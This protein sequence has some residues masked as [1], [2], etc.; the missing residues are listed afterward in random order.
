MPLAAGEVAMSWGAGLPAPRLDS[1]TAVYESVLPGVDLRVRALVDGFT[2]A[3]VVQSAEAADNPALETLRFTLDTAGLAKRPTDS[4]GFDIVDSTGTPVLSTG[5]A[6]MWDSSSALRDEVASKSRALEEFVE[7]EQREALESVPDGARKAELPTEV[8]GSDLLVRPDLELLRGSDTTYPVVIDPWTTINRLRWGYSGT[9]DATRS[10]GVARVGRNPDGSGTYRSYFAFNLSGLSGKTVRSVKFLTEMT[11]SW[12]CDPSPVNLWRTADLTSSGKQ[13]WSG[14]SFSKWLEE[15]SG[16]AH[17][18]SGGT[19]CSNDPQPDKPM[20]FSSTTL[21]NDLI[22]NQ[23]QSNYTL[24]LSARKSDH[25]G[26]ST[27]SWWKKFDPA[28]TKLSVEYNTPPNAP[29]AGQLS[30]H[31]NYTSGAQACVT[32]TSRPM[33]RSD[34]PWL[35]ATLTDPDGANGGKLSGVFTLQKRN[36]SSWAAVSGWPKTDSGVASGAKAEVQLTTKTVDGEQ[37][38]WQVQTKDTLGG[39][40]DPSPWCE[41]YVDYSPPAVTPTVTPADGLY[42]ES[43]PL[44]TNDQVRGGVGYSGR[45]T[46]S[47]N[48]VADVYDYVYQIEGSTQLAVRAASLGGSA[49]VWVTPKHIG[50]N[51]LTVRSRDAAGNASDPYDY[52]FLADSPSAPTAVWAMN[53]GTG[54][55]LATTPAGGPIIT[56]HNNPSWTDG[57]V[58]GA[59]K[60]QGRDRAVGF[61]YGRGWGATAAAPPI[62]SSRS[63]SVAA[64]ARVLSPNTFGSVVAA[65]G[66]NNGAWQLQRDA[67]GGWFF[68]TFS[69][70]S[71]SHTRTSVTA[72]APAAINVWQHIA[73]VYD[74]GAQRIRI[75]VN[76]RLAGEQTLNSLW[77]STGV[78]QIGRVHYNGNQ[79]N[80]FEGD[81]DDVR[82]WNRVID[83]YDLE[84]LV[85]PVLSGHWEMEDLDDDSPRQEA[86]ASGY[87]RPLTLADAPAVDWAPGLGYNF[88]SGLSFDG[89]N[90]AATT[91]GPVIRTDQSYTVSAWARWTGGSGPRTVFAQDGS[92]ISGFFLTCRLQSNTVR[93]S[94][95]T[96]NI[97]AT[98]S[99]SRT[100]Y[101][102]PCVQDKWTHVTA[103]QDA[104]AQVLRLYIDG[105]LAGTVAAPS[106]WHAAGA[107]TIGRSKYQIPADHWTGDIDRVRVWQG[108]LTDAEITAQVN[109]P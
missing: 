60:T 82:L 29:T 90:G 97:D 46:F 107:F 62:D 71:P 93:W 17:K 1:D 7:Q 19:G 13:A 10:D 103:V 37:Y 100:I 32:G 24:A 27:E 40:S 12:S 75:Y 76:G 55:T 48:G 3:F 5:N 92:Q 59:H 58:L 106:P 43:P 9:Q 8:H 79:Q 80:Y 30:T 96:R 16:N 83:E 52:V 63:F 14:P 104:N 22:A 68:H 84:P 31:A 94:L 66:T 38:R 39:T 64:W 86:D 41:F 26:E 81:I 28:L 101:G 61:G 21:K 105:V 34:Y 50:E 65:S 23:G 77:S 56:T 45:F 53:E 36:G 33:V 44:G 18:P 95:M 42:L 74:A 6:L 35:K 91:T 25:S 15:R 49:T 89:T 109:E 108:A 54:S 4:G 78:M 57:R 73:G 102:S 98:T 72:P 99:S 47:A 88:S 2:W 87:Q 85:E 67:G 11:H 69:G 20:E 51:V 70:D